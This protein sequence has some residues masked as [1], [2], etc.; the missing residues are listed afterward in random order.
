[1][2]TKLVYTIKFAFLAIFI[3]VIHIA[4]AQEVASFKTYK[5][6]VKDT[7]SKEN[8]V[9]GSVSVVGTN[10]GTVTNSEGEF[11]IKVLDNL[12]AKE[13]EFSHIGYNSKKVAI[14]NLSEE[15]NTI[16][17][18]ASSINLSEITVRPEDAS[19][20][21]QKVLKQI[22]NNY[23]EASLMSTGFYRETI[24]QSRD[25]IAISEALVDIYKAPYNAETEDMVKVYKGRKS[26]NV[27]KADTLAVK[28]QGGPYT[29]LLFDVA[30][31]PFIL[32]DLEVISYYNF[33]IEG[34]KTIDNN[35]NYV[36]H[37]SPKA[38]LI[39]F[40]MYEG[41]YYIEINSLAITSVEFSLDISDKE[42]A[43]M[44]F[45]KKKP[46]GLKLTPTSTHYLVSYKKVEDKY[47][48][49]YS[50][51]E[52]SF[53]CNW[54]KRLFNSNYAVMSEMA[55]TDWNAQEVDKFKYKDALKKNAVFEEEVAAFM[56]DDFWG[57]HNVIE[58]TESIESALK[59][60]SKKLQRK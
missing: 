53:K 10:V 46:I 13:I 28:L 45:V 8:V 55:I 36:V 31:N 32:L 25:Y 7:K 57:E 22:P 12:N 14:S 15:D 29:N 50:R 1:M 6:F 44:M 47:Y 60:Y 20:L 26:S 5:G 33:N 41:T 27:K 51:G 59:K 24:K 11:T 49:N 42:K 40:P 4:N 2:K 52:F 9:F 38:T 35:L 48:F 43:S 21:M 16:Y 58:P 18:E 19:A 30:K 39:D 54:K 23:S 34:M 56:D 3:F 37:F 17:L